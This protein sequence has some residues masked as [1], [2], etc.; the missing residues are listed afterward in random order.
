MKKSYT[1]SLE[2]ETFNTFKTICD[3]CMINKSAY[4]ESMIAYFNLCVEQ[5]NFDANIEMKN[6]SNRLKKLQE[7]KQLNDKKM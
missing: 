1:F 2:Q 4:L 3:E 7:N 6:I 5:G